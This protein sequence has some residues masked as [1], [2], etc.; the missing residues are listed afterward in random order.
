MQLYNLVKH[1]MG[2]QAKVIVGGRTF[3]VALLPGIGLV[4]SP[5]ELHCPFL[6]LV[7]KSD[8]KAPDGVAHACLAYGEPWQVSLCQPFPF[9]Q[10]DIGRIDG[11]E[12][13]QV[14]RVLTRLPRCGYYLESS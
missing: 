7:G 4:K 9:S 11:Q 8:P 10:V 14:Q 12:L 5:T 1:A 6:D 13:Q 3:E 2:K